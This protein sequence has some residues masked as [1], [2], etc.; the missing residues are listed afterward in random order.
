METKV[1]TTQTKSIILLK[2]NFIARVDAD[3][4]ESISD[5]VVKYTLDETEVL[6]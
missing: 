3:F 1:H 4:S 2:G 5:E 6:A